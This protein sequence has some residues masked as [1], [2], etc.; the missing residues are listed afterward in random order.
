[1]TVA[2]R[3]HP[4]DDAVRDADEPR[5]RILDATVVCLGRYGIGKT[6][7]EDAAREA[8]VSRATLYRYF[9]G[10]RDELITETMSLEVR[11]F[12]VRLAQV[13]QDVGDV[14]TRLERGLM[15]AHQAVEDHALLQKVLETEPERLLPHLTRSS[16]M[17]LGVLH[18]YLQPFLVDEALRPGLTV[19]RAADWLAR[20]TLSFIIAPGRWD[21]TDRADVRRLVRSHLLAGVLETVPEAGTATGS[22]GAP[23][24]DAVATPGPRPEPVAV[25]AEPP[26]AG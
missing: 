8:G 25:A 11:R 18:D 4:Y 19:D 21:L 3:L 9:P 14:A 10:G 17:V 26:P 12:F 20:M 5:D 24:G 22:G 6:T 13:V 15:F 1:V 23:P 7:V 16:P 2:T